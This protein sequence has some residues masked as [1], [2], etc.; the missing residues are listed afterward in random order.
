MSKATAIYGEG[1][2]L[3]KLFITSDKSVDILKLATVKDVNINMKDDPKG[4]FKEINLTLVFEEIE[5]P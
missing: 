3:K 4:S 2:R 1:G 5:I